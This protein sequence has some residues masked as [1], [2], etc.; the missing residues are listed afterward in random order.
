MSSNRRVRS[1]VALA[2]A[3]GGLLAVSASP[4]IAVTPLSI[5]SLYCNSAGG[6]TRVCQAVVSGGTGNYTYT[7]AP[8]PYST[9]E[10]APGEPYMVGPCTVDWESPASLT[11]TDGSSTVMAST[12][13]YCEA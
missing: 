6:G 1:V 2:A 10:S 7:W 8:A 5:D 12:S 13:T 11:V 4:G 3:A 9:G